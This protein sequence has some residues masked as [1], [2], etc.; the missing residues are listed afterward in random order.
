MR[1][2]CEFCG[3]TFVLKANQ[4]R[5]VIKKDFD[6]DA[7][8]CRDIIECPICGGANNVGDNVVWAAKMEKAKKT[9]TMLSF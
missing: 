3:E 4:L 6:T 5:H 9:I 2:E 1:L 7:D 8:V